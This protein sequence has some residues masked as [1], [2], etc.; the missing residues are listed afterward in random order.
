MFLTVKQKV[1]VTLL[2]KSP[3]QNSQIAKHVGITEQWF[4]LTVNALH[5]EG[6]V[7]SEFMTPRRINRLTSRGVEVA[8]HLK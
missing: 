3:F 6:L 1:L 2:E 8:K 5:V 4:S 7:K